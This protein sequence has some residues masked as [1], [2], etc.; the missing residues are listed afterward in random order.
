MKEYNGIIKNIIINESNLDIISFIVKVGLKTTSITLDNTPNLINL[1]IGDE[2]TIIE[3][4][5][6]K[7]KSYSIIRKGDDYNG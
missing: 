7:N 4:Q 6:L 2:V 1:H 5:I 3:D